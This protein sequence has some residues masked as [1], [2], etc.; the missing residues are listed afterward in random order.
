MISTPD[1]SPVA[2][3]TVAKVEAT[4]GPNTINRENV[5]RRIVVQANVADRDLAGVVTDIQESVA[6]LAL[7]QGYY[8]EYGGQFEA[9][10]SGKLSAAGLGSIL[11]RGDLP[12]AVQGTRIVA[13]GLAESGSTFRWRRL[14]PSSRCS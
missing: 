5:M 9:A 13:S 10:A 3:G 1:G 6:K 7:P 11:H 14:G 4:T 8:V 2:L 12:L